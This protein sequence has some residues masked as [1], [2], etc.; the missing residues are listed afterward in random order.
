[1]NSNQIRAIRSPRQSGFTLIELIVVIVILGILAATALPKFVGL[2][3]DARVASLNGV[4]GSMAATVAMVHG[5]YLI[6]PGS[7]PTVTAENVTVNV[8][9]GYPTADDKFVT[10][11]GLSSADY[12]TI[13]AGTS[14]TAATSTSPLVP[15]N[16][17]GVIPKSVAGTTAAVN[18]FVT[19][20][21]ALNTTTPPSISAAPTADQ[22]NG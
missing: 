22:C 10:A 13:V 14:A 9:N 7:T 4:R 21:Q 12:T 20:T 18:C 3:G 2:S 11:V 16:S 5:K 19:Y 8:T 1:M 17:V 15:A 6:N